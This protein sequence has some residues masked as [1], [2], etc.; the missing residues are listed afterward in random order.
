MSGAYLHAATIAL[1]AGVG[2]PSRLF[3]SPV[4]LAILYRARV[5]TWHLGAQ[6]VGALAP[7]P[8]RFWPRSVFAAVVAALAEALLQD[9][10]GAEGLDGTDPGAA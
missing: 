8:S 5:K 7:L 4:S 6:S 1:E 3:W 2:L 10:A 9:L